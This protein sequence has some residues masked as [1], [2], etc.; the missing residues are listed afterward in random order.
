VSQQR[1]LG[2]K[3]DGEEKDENKKK[4]LRTRRR[5]KNISCTSFTASEK[6]ANKH[7]ETKLKLMKTQRYRKWKIIFKNIIC[8]KKNILQLRKNQRD[9]ENCRIIKDKFKF[10]KRNKKMGITMNNAEET[11]EGKNCNNKISIFENT[12]MQS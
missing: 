6:E 11:E 8:G 4:K 5:R 3:K 12:R 9:K 10:R 2:H 1:R 7:N